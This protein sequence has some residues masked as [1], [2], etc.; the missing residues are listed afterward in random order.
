[1][2][3]ARPPIVIAGPTASG[4]SALAL[5]L[6]E[7]LGGEIVCADSRQVYR[8]MP[9]A[10]AGPTDSERA[11]VPH[12]GDQSCAP[13]DEMTAGRF[14]RAADAFVSDISARGKLPILV[15]GTGLYLRAWRFGL[16]DAAP[17]DPAIKQDLVLALEAQ[18]LSALVQMLREQA[19][20]I[21]ETLDANNPAR[22]LRALELVLS[23]QRDRPRDIDALLARPPRVQARWLLVDA[24]L[25]VLEPFMRARAEAMFATGLLDEARALAAT[26]PA[27]HALLH[28][29][30]IE[31]A[32][33]LDAGVLSRAEAVSKT[34][35]RTRQYARRQRTWFKK[36]PWW[37]RLEAGAGVIDQALLALDEPAS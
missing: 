3:D 26:L 25:E 10:S 24:P 23:G 7:R 19:P 21:L 29:I 17:V 6:A 18:G 22:V 5:A 32:L 28:T 12:H 33:A 37:V 13:D 20:E 1:M 15:G 2:S 30:G 16:D 11:R 27:G 31:E 35:L 9:I 36:E 4:K 14:S 8:G 34:T